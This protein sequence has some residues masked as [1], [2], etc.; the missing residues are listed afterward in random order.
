MDI[1]KLSEKLN[2]IDDS[3]KTDKSYETLLKKLK[4]FDPIIKNLKKKYG[5]K[6]W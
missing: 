2:K 1:N 4:D 3:L 5:G 6:I